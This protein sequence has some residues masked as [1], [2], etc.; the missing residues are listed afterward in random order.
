MGPT[1]VLDMS[2]MNR[3]SSNYFSD[4]SVVGLLYGLERRGLLPLAERDW[5]SELVRKAEV[6]LC[7]GPRRDF[8]D[9]EIRDLDAAVRNGALLFFALGPWT[10][11]HA[12]RLLRY[13]GVDVDGT[14]LGPVPLDSTDLGITMCDA[15]PLLVTDPSVRTICRAYGFTLVAGKLLGKGCLLAAGDE[16]FLLGENLEMVRYYTPVY[17]VENVAFFDKLLSREFCTLLEATTSELPGE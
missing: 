14:P 8:S 2:H 3:C 13:V 17:R 1:A 4:N 5:R 7:L 11:R 10:A 15:Y 9:S 12:P 6:V 16:C